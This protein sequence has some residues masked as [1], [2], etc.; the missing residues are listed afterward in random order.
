MSCCAT[1][2]SSTV[3]LTQNVVQALPFGTPTNVNGSLAGQVFDLTFS[4]TSGQVVSVAVTG[5]TYP[6]PFGAPA[7]L[8]VALVAPN[9]TTLNSANFC[10]SGAFNSV[11]LP[12]S[13][14]YTVVLNP[15][16]T[17]GS[18]TVTL[19][20]NVVQALP[21]GTPTNLNG[22]L[23][24]LVFDLTFSGTTGQVVSVAVT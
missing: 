11:T 10:G 9:G 23:A 17:T 15:G 24:G 18:A 22:S 8:N 1:T 21:F 6:C 12:Q 7:A 2:G 14:T 5:A 13:G 16:A 3:T 4:G 20:Q 19:T